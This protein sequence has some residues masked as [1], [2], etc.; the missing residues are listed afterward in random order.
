MNLILVRGLPGSG[1]STIAKSLS[2]F[3]HLETD[4]FWGPDYIF[5]ISRIREAHEWCQNETERHLKLGN[6]VVVSNTFTTLKEMRP[7]FQMAGHHN[8]KPQVILA[9]GQWKNVHNVPAEVLGKMKE[10]F[11]FDISYLY[12]EF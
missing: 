7:Y 4:Q 5:D 8:I 6:D 12:K 10:R 2:N 9:Q 1:K 3:I 11:E